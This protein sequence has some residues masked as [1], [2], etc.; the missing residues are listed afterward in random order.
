VNGTGQNIL[1]RGKDPK[2]WIVK[3]KKRKSLKGSMIQNRAVTE[4][5]KREHE[6]KGGRE[7]DPRETE[8]KR[9]EERTKKIT[10]SL[11]PTRRIPIYGVL[12]GKKRNLRSK[13]VATEGVPV[14]TQLAEGG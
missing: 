9:R 8:A 7:G 3:E 14:Q 10:V 6:R 1:P 5:H 13:S 2:S 11:G 12:K 4:T